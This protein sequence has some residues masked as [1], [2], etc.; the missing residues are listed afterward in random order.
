MAVSL[1]TSRIVLVV[2]GIVDFGVYNVI[3]GVVVMFGFLNSAM[4]AS[5]E[6]FLTFEL[7]KGDYLRLK[8]IF[9][10]S[11]TLHIVIS[12]IIL[13]LS[14]TLGIWFLNNKL[15]IPPERLIAANWVFQFSVFTAMITILSVPYNAVI[16]AHERMNVFAYVSIIEVILK[17]LIVY[18]LQLFGYDKLVF[19]AILIF[20]VSLV[21][22]IIYGIYCARNF[23]ESHYHFFWDK[24][25]FS[26]MMGF[27]GWNLLGV[28]AGIGYNQGVNI[29]LN[30]FFGPVVNAARGIAFQIMGAINQLVT[31]FQIAI[32]PPIIKSYAEKDEKNMYSLIFSSS[33]FSYFLLLLFIVP[34]IIEAKFVLSVWLKEVPEH[35]VLFTRLVLIDILICSLSGPLQILA[36]ATGKVRKYQLVVSIILLLNLPVSYLLLKMGHAPESTFIVSILLSTIALFARLI[37]LKTLTMFPVTAFLNKVFLTV[38]TVTI[39]TV[40]I[41][42]F[43]HK[44]ISHTLLQ[45]LLVTASSAVSLIIA[46]WFIGLSNLERMIFKTYLEK[47]GLR[48]FYTK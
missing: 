24:K 45:F 12:I 28:F 33:K 35:T 36:Q 5:T 4:A 47:K 32:N 37:V 30:I 48:N 13:I 7:G 19:Y 15:N 44:L 17:L 8:Q 3:A 2:L 1:Y 18:V 26:E 14:E 40:P 38:I 29:L 6:R 46:V 9:S 31:N 20:L 11:V 43:T 34:L 25:L 10:I 16:I 39:F 21:L 27:A 22:R 42:I 41:P 23:E